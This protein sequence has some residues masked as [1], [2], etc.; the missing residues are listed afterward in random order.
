MG[1]PAAGSAHGSKRTPEL[2][3]AAKGSA[4]LALP[5][6][7]GFVVVA[8]VLM[9]AGAKVEPVIA[10]VLVPT[11]WLV[12]VVELLWH[13]VIPRALQWQYLVFIT[14]GPYAGSALGVYGY[15]DHWDKVVHFDSGIMLAW[16]GLFAVRRVE[17]AVRVAL[18]RWFGLAVSV[19]TPMAFAA[20]WEICEF[21]SDHLFGT[22][23]QNGNTDTMGDIIAATIG[24]LV[25]LGITLVWRWPGSVMPIALRR[26]AAADARDEQAA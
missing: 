6:Q 3:R 13:T 11:L 12:P 10:I 18:P 20:A 24:A 22:H 7:I 19:A 25:T 9:L 5:F 8:L 1:E 15:I 23:A 14:I 17:D 2:V 4:L 16:A 26:S 21:T